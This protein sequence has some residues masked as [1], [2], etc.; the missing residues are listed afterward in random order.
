MTTI[1]FRNGGWG[2]Y[3]HVAT[4]TERTVRKRWFRWSRQATVLVHCAG[5]WAGDRIL[6]RANGG[7]RLADVVG[8]I[9]LAQFSQGSESR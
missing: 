9:A 7:D 8:T 2:H 1:D 4:W 3:L 6:Y 5:V